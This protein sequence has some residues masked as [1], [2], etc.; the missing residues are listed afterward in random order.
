MTPFGYLL[1]RPRYASRVCAVLPFSFSFSLSLPS[2]IRFFDR[3][4]PRDYSHGTRHTHTHSR[5]S[6]RIF[7]IDRLLYNFFPAWDFAITYRIY[8]YIKNALYTRIWDL[9]MVVDFLSVMG[10][11]EKDDISQY[12]VISFGRMT[13]LSR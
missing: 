11:E 5:T 13:T 4:V 3:K 10:R 1:A 7:S 9:S 6:D 12:F 2:T 8:T